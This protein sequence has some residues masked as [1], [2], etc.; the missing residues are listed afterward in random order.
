MFTPFSTLPVPHC[1]FHFVAIR[2]VPSYDSLVYTCGVSILVFVGQAAMLGSNFAHG[3]IRHCYLHLNPVNPVIADSYTNTWQV[4]FLWFWLYSL[5]AAVKSHRL[6]VR[7]ELKVLTQRCQKKRFQ[8][9][10]YQM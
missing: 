7:L 9:N 6:R 5:C 10:R 3:E 2:N 8:K 1:V 4:Y